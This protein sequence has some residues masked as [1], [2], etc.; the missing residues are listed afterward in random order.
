MLY[1][2]LR[3]TSLRVDRRAPTT[4]LTSQPGPICALSNETIT[5]TRNDFVRHCTKLRTSS[6]YRQETCSVLLTGKAPVIE[7]AGLC[8]LQSLILTPLGSPPEGLKPLDIVRVSEQVMGKICGLETI[9]AEQAVAAEVGL[10]AP[11]DLTD[12]FGQAQLRRLLI[13]D[14]LQDPGNMGTLLRTAHALGWQAAFLLPGC[15]DPFND[16]VLRAARGVPLIF[17]LQSGGWPELQAVLQHHNLTCLA[18]HAPGAGSQWRQSLVTALPRLLWILNNTLN[19]L[20]QDRALELLQSVLDKGSQAA[21]QS[22]DW[23][24][25]EHMRADQ[26]LP[27]EDGATHALNCLDAF[28]GMQSGLNAM[29]QDP[30]LAEAL[31]ATLNF[32][33]SSDVRSA[34]ITLIA[35]LL[36][37]GPDG[38]QGM[39]LLACLAKGN[40][41]PAI[42]HALQLLPAGAGPERGAVLHICACMARWD[43]RNSLPL[44]TAE[45]LAESYRSFVQSIE[46]PQ[47]VVNESPRCLE[48]SMD[49]VTHWSAAMSS[50][51]QMH[52]HDP[53]H[54]QLCH[55]LEQARIAFDEAAARWAG[56]HQQ[57]N[58]RPDMALNSNSPSPT[59]VLAQ[60]ME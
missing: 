43:S 45:W 33:S 23:E 54:S 58:A 8:K 2:V 26:K 7:L 25:E 50:W 22:D 34:C 53:A 52:A 20:L 42:G 1:L 46:G 36:P 5:S 35:N 32:A 49:L 4:H 48:A 57:H 47:L 30:R 27:T 16:K 40:C 12:H 21:A 19:A 60:P 6:R 28:T 15:C 55:Q 17:P 11:K 38:G 3:H 9:S 44:E 29:R 41:L 18:A 56:Q 14:G 59:S 37:S 51:Q 39:P 31:P 24:A 10:P 13:L